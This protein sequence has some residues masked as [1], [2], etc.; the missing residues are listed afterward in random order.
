MSLRHEQQRTNLR[1]DD[2]H[3][4]QSRGRSIQYNTKEEERKNYEQTD[5]TERERHGWR[6]QRSLTDRRHEEE[7]RYDKRSWQYWRRDRP[8]QQNDWR[9]WRS[10]HHYGERQRWQWRADCDGHR[11]HRSYGNFLQHYWDRDYGQ[12]WGTNHR[13]QEQP[14]GQYR[15]FR[16]DR[17]GN[18]LPQ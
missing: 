4:N 6:A 16:N 7:R 1:K 17:L 12:N 8:T 5:D 18:Y 10:G 13:Q 15:R 14:N 2:F 9:D 3:K 11:P